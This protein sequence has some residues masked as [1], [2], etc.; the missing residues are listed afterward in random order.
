[1]HRSVL[2]ALAVA[3]IAAIGVAQAQTE[4]VRIGIFDPET[5][6]RLTDVGKR[7]NQ[8]LSE[9]RDRLQGTI[10]KK[11]EDAEAMKA[12]LRQQQHSL[13]EEKQQQMQKDIQNRLIDLNRMQDDATREMKQQLTDVQN[14]F[15]QML[16][17]TLQTFGK[18]KGFTLILNNGVIDYAAP[19]ID[20]TQDLIAKFNEMHKVP[21]AS[22]GKSPSKQ[23]P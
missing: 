17:D 10:D 13:S 6:W 12:K 5:V 19:Q 4:T 2:V 9:A 20:V 8:D 7:Y 14:R 1:M 11:S 23:T 22:T 21:A 15:Q 18:E 16:L 3:G